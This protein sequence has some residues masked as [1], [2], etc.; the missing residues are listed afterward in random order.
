[1]L[2]SVFS[3]VRAGQCVCVCSAV[4]AEQCVLSSVCS[5]QC[6]VCHRMTCIDLCFHHH[7]PVVLYNVRLAV[8]IVG[9]RKND[10]VKLVTLAQPGKSVHVA[11]NG[12]LC[13]LQIQVCHRQ[14][15]IAGLDRWTDRLIKTH[16]HSQAHTL[17]QLVPKSRGRPTQ[18]C[19]DEESPLPST[20]QMNWFLPCHLVLRKMKPAH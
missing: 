1:M 9:F 12:L 8:L 20:H 19:R 11:I 14:N 5:H 3:A 2:I 13:D 15:M 16:A 4:C 7:V 10:C 17:I 6:V 18:V